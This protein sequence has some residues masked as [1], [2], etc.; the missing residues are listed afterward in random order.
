[1]FDTYVH[2]TRWVVD[3]DESGELNKID[4]FKSKNTS[5][6]YL[7]KSKCQHEQKHDFCGRS[8]NESLHGLQFLFI[9]SVRI[10]AGASKGAPL[11]GA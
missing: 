3:S 8:L 10:F 2:T 6:S 5:R 1:M 4:L 11:V 9:L 7:Q